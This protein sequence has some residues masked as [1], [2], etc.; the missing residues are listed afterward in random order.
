MADSPTIAALISGGVFGVLGF[1]A[2]SVWDRY[3]ANYDD[4]RLNAW[5]IRADYLER[6]LSQFY[7]PIYIRL[8]RDN[9]VW[10][11]ILERTNR[12]EG[13]K[14]TLG[15]EIDKNVLLPNNLEIAKIIQANIHLADMDED[16]EKKLMEFLRHVDVYMSL[17]SAGIVDKDPYD[18]G[19]PFPWWLFDAIKTRLVKYQ[20]EYDELIRDH[21]L[22]DRTQVK[23]IRERIWPASP[24][25]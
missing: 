15:Y 9:V 11:R 17:R 13:D 20:A 10:E 14:S 8:Q 24:A 19:E 2:K 1:A 18:F 3:F 5:K 16:L 23:T 25:A 7:W 21:G 22:F 12:K 6:R 4:V